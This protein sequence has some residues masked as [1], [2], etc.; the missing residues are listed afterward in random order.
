MSRFFNSSLLTKSKDS[1]THTIPDPKS[2]HDSQVDLS[3][4]KTQTELKYSYQISNFHYYREPL[5]NCW[6]L[7]HTLPQNCR[8]FL[9]VW[10]T[11]T[12]KG[13]WFPHQNTWQFLAVLAITFHY[14]LLAKQSAIQEVYVDTLIRGSI[15]LIATYFTTLF[16]GLCIR[17]WPQCICGK[18]VCY[19]F[20]EGDTSSTC[21]EQHAVECR[22]MPDN[23][24]ARFSLNSLH[25]IILFISKVQSSIHPPYCYK[26]AQTLFESLNCY[27]K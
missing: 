5:N 21:H 22:C 7:K 8:Q 23:S 11:K 24:Y 25:N 12:Q 16:I 6:R 14:K 26:T 27:H 10:K 13:D 17:L 15:L 2:C 9:T 3:H 1:F 4:K 19:S 18:Y 20:G